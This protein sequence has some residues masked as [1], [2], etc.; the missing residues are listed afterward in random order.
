LTEPIPIANRKVQLIGLD[1]QE[2][3]RSFADRT[4][5]ALHRSTDDRGIA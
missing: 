3:Q 5:S 1:S 2:V 4:E